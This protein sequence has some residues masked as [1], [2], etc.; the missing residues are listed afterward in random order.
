MNVFNGE[1]SSVSYLQLPVRR[2][3]ENRFCTRCS[4][5]G[6][7]RLYCQVT[8]WC[9]FCTS[10]THATQAC[11]KYEKF[12]KDNPTASSRRNTPV[13]GQRASVN[14]REPTQRPLFPHLPVQ[15][16]NPT[17]IPR[18]T[19]NTLDPQGKE[20]DF[21]EHSQNL[22][23]NQMKEIRTSMSKQLPHQRSCQDV[24]MDPRYQKPPQ[25]AEINYH[26]P[27][28]QT[29]IEVNEIGP[30]IQQGVIQRPVQR[31]TQAAGE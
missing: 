9:K 6:H 25:Y 14:T 12:I 26:Q 3:E 13:Q 1:E 5:M 18:M 27:S 7:G 21:K 15:C 16:F 8:T 4:K 10:D 23:Q 31:H 24:R 30:T 20:S 19:T 17:V 11:Q 29:L 28:P 2:K 22:P